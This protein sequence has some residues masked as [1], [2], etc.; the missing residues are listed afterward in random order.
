VIKPVVIIAEYD[1]FEMNGIRF[2]KDHRGGYVLR[3]DDLTQRIEKTLSM[4]QAIELAVSIL[5][6]AEA[7]IH[8]ADGTLKIPK[9]I[10]EMTGW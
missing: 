6:Y 7:V 5:E 3:V 4:E 2:R 8:E 10:R 1:G 9:E